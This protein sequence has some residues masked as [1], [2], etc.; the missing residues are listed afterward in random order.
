MAHIANIGAGM[1]SDLSVEVNKHSVEDIK[2]LLTAPT[3][4]KFHAHFKDMIDST[5]AASTF[6][7]ELAE[8]STDNGKFVRIDNIREFPAIGTPPN[9]VNVPIY[10]SKTSRQIQG[11]SDAPSMEL[12]INYVGSDW[13]KARV[14]GAMV[15]D[16]HQYVFRFTL[17]NTEPKGYA[18]TAGEDNLGSV[19][20]TIYYFVGKIEA[21]QV[22]PQ[23]TDANQATLTI[24]VQSEMFGAYTINAA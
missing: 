19:Q 2:A 11:Q 16:G 1:Y 10:G 3:D 15:G 20:N 12:T 5:S 21:L 6:V 23:L 17:M 4:A 7:N 18:S 14:L 24:S 22:T 9:I 13:D 8:G